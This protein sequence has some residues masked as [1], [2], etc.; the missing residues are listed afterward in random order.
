MIASPRPPAIRK[1]LSGSLLNTLRAPSPAR[2]FM[3]MMSA[4]KRPSPKANDEELRASSNPFAADSLTLALPDTFD[5]TVQALDTVAALHPM[6]IVATGFLQPL[7]AL[8]RPDAVS[9]YTLQTTLK[10]LARVASDNGSHTAFWEAGAPHVLLD[11]LGSSAG[12]LGGLRILRSLARADASAKDALRELGIIRPLIGLLHAAVAPDADAPAVDAAFAA[13][14]VM[15][16][17]AA[18]NATNQESLR[19]GGAIRALVHLFE[20]KVARPTSLARAATALSNLAVGNQ[21]S[22]NAIRVAGAIPRL[23][24]LLGSGDVAAINAATEALGNLAVKNVDNKEAV[25][26]AGGVHALTEQLRTMR[27]RTPTRER[28]PAASRSSSPSGTSSGPPSRSPSPPSPRSGSHGEGGSHHSQSG[29]E[30]ERTVTVT[31]GSGRNSPL[32]TSGRAADSKSFFAP[33]PALQVMLQSEMESAHAPQGATAAKS[34][35]GLLPAAA[36]PSA[37]TAHELSVVTP[38]SSQ[39]SYAGTTPADS[40]RPSDPSCSGA[41]GSSSALPTPRESHGGHTHRSS[42]VSFERT[43]WALRI[44]VTSNGLNAAAVV[45]AGVTLKELE[46]I[47]AAKPERG[48]AKSTANASASAAAAAGAPL[49]GRAVAQI[50]KA[51]ERT[52]P[53]PVPVPVPASKPQPIGKPHEAELEVAPTNEPTA[54]K[55]TAMLSVPRVAGGSQPSSTVRRAS[56]RTKARPKPRR[57]ARLSHSPR[58]GPQRQAPAVSQKQT[59]SHAENASPQTTEAAEAAEAEARPQVGG[60]AGV[61][62][63][64]WAQTKG[65]S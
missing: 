53:P 16:N 3:A 52:R 33:Q 37:C 65:R 40:P 15:S 10:V 56:L 46:A 61:G 7:L 54:G 6:A 31:G 43:A 59:R 9:A 17:L 1:T 57:D 47:G 5:T 62:L 34:A 14:G 39:G 44:L 60:G 35:G 18:S 26:T 48:A 13:V 36:L 63:T 38:E 25:R 27:G 28:T 19:N 8:L 49:I 29:T 23:V 11:L 24:E 22:K 12:C 64:I 58:S 51:G 41:S 20:L 30:R 42:E 32:P 45:G 4:P 21:A 50:G 55:S 2:Q